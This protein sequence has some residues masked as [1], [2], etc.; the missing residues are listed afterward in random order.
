MLPTPKTAYVLA[1]ANCL[2]G[3]LIVTGSVSNI[4]VVQQARELEID[5][6]FRSVPLSCQ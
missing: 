4:I 1:L 3:S 2:G 5:I 6:I